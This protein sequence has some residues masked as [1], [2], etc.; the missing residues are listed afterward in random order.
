MTAI[1]SFEQAKPQLGQRVFIAENAI[2]VGDVSLG[3]DASVWFGAVL[4]GDVGAI[5][6]GARTNVQDLVCLHMTQAQNQV[7]IGEEVTVGHAAVIHGAT[8]G[9]GALIG[10]GALV[11]DDAEIGPEALVAAGSL[12]VPRMVV[13]AGAMVV[14][15]PARVVRQLSAEERARGR[16]SAR[17]YVELARA[18][19][20][21]P[22]AD[23]VHNLENVPRL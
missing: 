22:A 11:L 1:R 7:V 13:P 17:H 4:R 21:S 2:V 23:E 8:V 12:V 6:I 20:R 15:R 3:D 19:G 10:M 5:R 14:G 16:L 18:Y 9:D